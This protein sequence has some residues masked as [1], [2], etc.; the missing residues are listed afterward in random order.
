MVEQV[1]TELNYIAIEKVGPPRNRG[2]VG[3]FNCPCNQNYYIDLHARK[4][5]RVSKYRKLRWLIEHSISK[6]KRFG[7]IMDS[8]GGSFSFFITCV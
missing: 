7:Q 6:S 8:N 4:I 3:V 1:I 5:K 2:E